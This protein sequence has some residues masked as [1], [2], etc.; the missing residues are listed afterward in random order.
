MKKWER[1][2]LHGVAEKAVEVFRTKRKI[3]AKKAVQ[4]WCCCKEV[5]VAAKKSLI[6]IAGLSPSEHIDKVQCAKIFCC[7]AQTEL[8][9]W[10]QTSKKTFFDCLCM[11]T[12]KRYIIH[13]IFSTVLSMRNGSSV[14]IVILH[15][16]ATMSVNSNL[17]VGNYVIGEI[18]KN[19]VWCV[20]YIFAFKGCYKTK[21][22]ALLHL[23][24]HVSWQWLWLAAAHNSLSHRQDL[25]RRGA[26]A[27]FVSHA[28]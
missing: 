13:F 11:G 5:N 14:L 9:K 28:I 3:K 8:P 24:S 21:L 4:M 16:I 20:C 15:F 7:W 17:D 27:T 12:W 2:D 18:L 19:S 23:H 6:Y 1:K 10:W 22:K 26:T 25:F